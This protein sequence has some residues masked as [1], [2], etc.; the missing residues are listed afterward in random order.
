MLTSDLL[1]TRIDDGRV[2]PEYV[3]PADDEAIERAERL[4]EIFENRVGEPRG[5]IDDAVDAAVGYGTDYK[6]WRGFAKLLY[7]RSEFETSAPADP[8]DIR[9]EVFERAAQTEGRIGGEWRREVYDRAA[10]RFDDVEPDQL[11]NSLYADL[12]DRQL[13]VEFDTIGA[14]DLIDRYNLALAQAVLYR[15]VE[16]EVELRDLSPNLLRYLFQS[17][18]FNRLMHR[19]ERTDEGYRLR[20]DGP[21]S[22][23]EKSR[24][25][26]IR[27][28]RFLPAL[29]LADDWTMRAELEWE[30]ETRTFRLSDEA[31]LVSHYSPDAQWKADEEAYF[32]EQFDDEETDWELTREGAIL[33][34]PDNEVIVPDYRLEHPDGREAYLEIVGFWRTSYLE[35]RIDLLRRAE[36]L[37]LV[38]AVSER[39]NAGEAA[40]EASPASVFFF[41]T[42]ILVDRVIECVEEVAREP[43]SG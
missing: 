38:L 3:D 6:V 41:K 32:E 43:E 24:K 14:R 26:G 17:L 22:L 7:D 9:R 5:E 36:N 31:P 25:Y 34:L 10:E 8:V 2:E 37:P 15:A 1:Q 29:V 21:A 39:L 28:A 12:E 42:V 11:A 35:R 33:E 20:L 16:L 23:F 30:D 4:V 19:T 40:F 18:K 13:L 27:L